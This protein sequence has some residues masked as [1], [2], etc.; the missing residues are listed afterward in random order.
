[1]KIPKSK[2]LNSKSN[3]SR[4]ACKETLK[5]RSQLR[6]QLRSSN[7]DTLSKLFDEMSFKDCKND[8]MVDTKEK[9]NEKEN[10]KENEKKSEYESESLAIVKKDSNINDCMSGINGIDS[11]INQFG[12]KLEIVPSK[13]L[14]FNFPNNQPKLVS[15]K[16]L[17]NLK[18]KNFF[19]IIKLNKYP[20]NYKKYSPI[21]NGAI[22]E[23]DEDGDGDKDDEIDHQMSE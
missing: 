22:T 20:I 12:K 16:S 14:Y 6:N 9:E 18:L 11:L 23:I 8:M 3:I 19:R 10:K 5:K 1:M 7:V 2:S 21:F 15:I 17:S 13:N 4:K